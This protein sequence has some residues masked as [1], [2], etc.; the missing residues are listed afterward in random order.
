MLEQKR[1]VC[2]DR[3]IRGP[4]CFLFY[5]DES[6]QFYNNSICSVKEKFID[7]EIGQFDTELLLPII[8]SKAL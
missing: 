1:V 7:T 8:K 4:M 6:T 5:V 3:S 2:L